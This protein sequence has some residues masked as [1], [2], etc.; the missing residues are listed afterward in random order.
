[1][2]RFLRKKRDKTNNFN[3]IKCKIGFIGPTLHIV[4]KKS[5]DLVP[6][7]K[8]RLFACQLIEPVDNS[9]SRYS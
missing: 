3:Y 1:M 7:S 2:S 5:L 6:T 8:S 9:L 4:Y